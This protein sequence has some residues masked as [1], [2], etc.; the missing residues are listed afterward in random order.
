MY[1]NIIGCYNANKKLKI[2]LENK[3]KVAKEEHESRLETMKAEYELKV[4]QYEENKKIDI[5]EKA[6]DI[7]LKNKSVQNTINKTLSKSFENM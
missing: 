3:L 2:D 7:V 4:K 5:T 6:F 1:L